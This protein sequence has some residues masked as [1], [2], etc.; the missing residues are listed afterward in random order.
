MTSKN[1]FPEEPKTPHE[2]VMFVVES[3]NDIVSKLGEKMDVI[4]KMEL[5]RLQTSLDSDMVAEVEIQEALEK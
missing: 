1:E 2:E 5:R 3:T 4:L